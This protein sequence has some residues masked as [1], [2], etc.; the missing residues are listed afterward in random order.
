MSAVKKIFVCMMICSML[1][2]SCTF[3][4]HVS[5]EQQIIDILNTALNNFAPHNWEQALQGVLD[6]LNKVGGDL[7]DRVSSDVR[8]LMDDA[9]TQVRGLTGALLNS[10]FCTVDFVGDRVEQRLKKI[11]HDFFQ[12]SSLMLITLQPYVQSIV[13]M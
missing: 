3:G 10:A 11:A 12:R 5:A 6:R 2:N 9:V 7:A 4:V 13:I 1:L 8:S